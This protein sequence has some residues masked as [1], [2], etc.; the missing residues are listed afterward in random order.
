MKDVFHDGIE[1]NVELKTHIDCSGYVDAEN[2]HD[3]LDDVF[4]SLIENC[5]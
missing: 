1:D 4:I 5:Q 3:H 2:F